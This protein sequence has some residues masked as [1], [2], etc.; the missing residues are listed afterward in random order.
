MLAEKLITHARRSPGR[1][2]ERAAGSVSPPSNALGEKRS[3]RDF[4]APL[5]V[6]A[7]SARMKFVNGKRVTTANGEDSQLSAK[8]RNPFMH[9]LRLTALQKVKRM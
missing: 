4:T 1:R 5:T 2:V 7:E 8:F 6:H 3:D 9:E